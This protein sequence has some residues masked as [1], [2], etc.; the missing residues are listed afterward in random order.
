MIQSKIGLFKNK[1]KKKKIIIIFLIFTIFHKIIM[2][3]QIMGKRKRKYYAE[4]KHVHTYTYTYASNHAHTHTHIYIYIHNPSLLYF[5]WP[6]SKFS[7][8]F[9]RVNTLLSSNDDVESSMF[10]LLWYMFM[11]FTFLIKKYN[12]TLADIINNFYNGSIFYIHWVIIISYLF[13]DWISFNINTN[14]VFVLL[15]SSFEIVDFAFI[16]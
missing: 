10:M 9:L 11:L 8:K 13:Y 5:F 7:T 3:L 4:D 2:F 15:K 16:L 14:I 12:F 1:K 6:V